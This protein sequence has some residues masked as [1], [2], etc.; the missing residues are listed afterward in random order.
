MNW[1]KKPLYRVER[2]VRD[3]IKRDK[4]AEILVEKDTIQSMFLN[5]LSKVN[6]PF[7]FKGGTSLSKAYNLINRF[8]EDI[9]LSMKKKPTQTEKKYLKM[10]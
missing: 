1:Y 8:S 5:E 9:D 6:L 7:V 2:G 4:K 10:K 3:S